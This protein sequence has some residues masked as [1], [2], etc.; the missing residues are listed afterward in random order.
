MSWKDT[1]TNEEVRVRTGQHSMDD[2]LSE[3]RPLAWT[4]D[5][6]GSSAYTSTGVALEGSGVQEGSRSSAC[7]L[8]EHR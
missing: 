5:T 2:I 6:N 3:R 4:C 7:K 8:E 1:V